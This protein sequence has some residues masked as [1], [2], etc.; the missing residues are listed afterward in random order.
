MGFSCH[1]NGE[2]TAPAAAAGGRLRARLGQHQD[3]V[4]L[5]RVTLLIV[6]LPPVQ[7]LHLMVVLVTGG[8]ATEQI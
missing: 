8:D 2:R 7:G 5:T 3:S 6:L 1:P 4:E